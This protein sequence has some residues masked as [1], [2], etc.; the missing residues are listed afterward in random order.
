MLV[1]VVSKSSHAIISIILQI[2]GEGKPENK[3]AHN[4]PF[5]FYDSIKIPIQ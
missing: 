2:Y 3:M 4:H 1:F 5:Q